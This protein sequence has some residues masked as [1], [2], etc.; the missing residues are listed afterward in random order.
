MTAAGCGVAEKCTGNSLLSSHAFE[1][2]WV[3]TVFGGRRCG[4]PTG[5]DRD[6]QPVAEDAEAPH[7]LLFPQAGRQAAR[8]QGQH[9]GHAG[10][11][12]RNPP[13]F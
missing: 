2:C 10:K 7:R 5:R 6:A 13:A 4:F 1:A 12:L 9:P 3:V 8:Q 11:Q